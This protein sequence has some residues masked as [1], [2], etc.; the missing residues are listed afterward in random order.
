MT[1]QMEMRAVKTGVVER[2]S[3]IPK[4]AV[5]PL[6]A[7]NR[8]ETNVRTIS[9]NSVTTKHTIR[10]HQI[11]LIQGEIVRKNTNIIAEDVAF[12][13]LTKF[14]KIG[15][16]SL[17]YK[18]DRYLIKE[19]NEENRIYDLMQQK[20]PLLNKFLPEYLG[21]IELKINDDLP[22][23]EYIILEDLTYQMEEPFIMDLKMGTRQYGLKSLEDKIKSQKLKCKN[24]TSLKLGVRLCGLQIINSNGKFELYDKYYG[25]Q[26]DRQQFMNN[27]LKFLNNKYAYNL[28]IKSLIIIKHLETIYGMIKD[29]N[30]FRLYGS[31]ILMIY[32][33]NDDSNVIIKLIDF[34]K[35]FIVPE[36][37][38]S[39]TGKS[40]TSKDY[41]YLK[42]I[43]NLIELIKLIFETVSHMK[44]DDNEDLM[45]KINEK[46]SEYMTRW[47]EVIEY[48]EFEYEYD[49]CVSD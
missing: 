7:G 30:N 18:Y 29:L 15:G 22:I 34:S 32:D 45:G 46:Q 13:T 38:C 19:M 14:N 10:K 44:Y 42:G 33:N 8:T 3:T 36:E 11:E 17:I 43:F 40:K 5:I 2:D 48:R 21:T 27:L 41:G 9:S 37:Q 6:A 47:S 16:H 31:S 1:E 28:L 35:S 25:R 4:E 12:I 23:Q 49:E 26:L 39:G 20:Y 24:S